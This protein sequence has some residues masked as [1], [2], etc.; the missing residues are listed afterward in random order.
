MRTVWP[1][2]LQEEWMKRLLITI[3][4]LGIAGTAWAQASS[5]TQQPAA[6]RSSRIYVEGGAGVTLG[7]VTSSTF[8][9]EVGFRF[10]GRLEAFGEFGRM[11]DITDSATLDA[12]AVIG[13]WLGTLGQGAATWTVTSPTNY[14]AAG[15]RF[16]F[17]SGGKVEPYAAVTM[18]VANVERTTTYA[19]NGTDVTGSLPSLGVT[20]GEDLS[21]K[22]NNFLLT[23]GGGVRISAGAVF[24]DAGARYGRIFTDAGTDT[25]RIYAGAGFRF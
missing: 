20:L 9:G 15:V 13:D 14:G 19:L 21:G 8:G 16:L 12:A 25:I 4:L 3:V 22:T 7:T 6:G 2:G 24:I 17:S 18:G 1:G 5:V 23:A 10:G 11:T